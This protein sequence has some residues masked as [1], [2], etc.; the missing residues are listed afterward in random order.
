[1]T[2]TLMIVPQWTNILPIEMPYEQGYFSGDPLPMVPEDIA[3]RLIQ[4]NQRFIDKYDEVAGW[5][6]QDLSSVHWA[7]AEVL[8][9]QL[10]EA[11]GDEYRII[12]T[13][14]YR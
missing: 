11:L 8:R 12:I 10:V 7:E 3:N 14:S 9:R 4:W 2:K 5:T 1:M 13:R 6:E